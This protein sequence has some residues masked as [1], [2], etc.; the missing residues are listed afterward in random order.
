M[1][2]KANKIAI[3]ESGPALQ[4]MLEENAFEVN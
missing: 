1:V 4:E 3:N 2:E